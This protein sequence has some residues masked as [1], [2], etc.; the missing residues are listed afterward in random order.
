MATKSSSANAKKRPHAEALRRR[1]IQGALWQNHDG[2]GNAFYVTSVTR[3]YKNG[4]GEWQNE[5]LYVPLDDAPR[6][7]EV[8]RELETKA[9]EAIEADYQAAREATA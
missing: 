7:C 1:N 5:V 2:D 6:V 8:L 9:Y 4:D 3:S